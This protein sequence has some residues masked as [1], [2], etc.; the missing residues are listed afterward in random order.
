MEHL[1][2]LG[3]EV[4]LHVE[5]LGFVEVLMTKKKLCWN[6]SNHLQFAKQAYSYLLTLYIAFDFHGINLDKQYI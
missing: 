4:D 2:H 5:L 3:F 6:C 1:S